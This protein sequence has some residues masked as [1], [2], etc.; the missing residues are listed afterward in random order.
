MER[1]SRSCLVV[2]E[3]TGNPAWAA[4]STSG[5]RSLDLPKDL[6]DSSSLPMAT[7]L[8]RR[9]C[10]TVPGAASARAGAFASLARHRAGLQQHAAAPSARQRGERAMNRRLSTR[11]QSLESEFPVEAIRQAGYQAIWRGEK[12][13]NGVAIF[14]KQA[15]DVI[16]LRGDWR[17]KTRCP[18]GSAVRVAQCRP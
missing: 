2:M 3:G 13:W 11:N 4:L 16:A 1:P 17:A 7:K 5:L 6:R 9:Q 10:A 12:P 8:A 15:P 14:A 18:T